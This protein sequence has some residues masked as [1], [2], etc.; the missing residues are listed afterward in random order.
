M[1]L[2]C[3]AGHDI[4]PSSAIPPSASIREG[5]PKGGVH[6][7]APINHASVTSPRAPGLVQLP[8]QP[9]QY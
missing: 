3:L 6:G 1:T 8:R 4:S 2:L 7:E 9:N 5:M